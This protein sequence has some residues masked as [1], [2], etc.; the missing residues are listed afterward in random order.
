M[1]TRENREE[2]SPEQKR[3]VGKGARHD[4][5][6]QSNNGPSTTQRGKTETEE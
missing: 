3:Q 4:K 6:E 5:E 2:Q 1:A